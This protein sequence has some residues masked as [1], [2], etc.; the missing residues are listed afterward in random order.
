MLHL[1]CG[2]STEGFV[3]VDIRLDTGATW[4]GDFRDYSEP[5]FTSV[6][7][8]PPYTQEFADVWNAKY[9]TP[10]E[11]Q[12]V[13][14]RCL[15]PGGILGILHLQVIRPYY[16]FK[17]IAWHPVFCGTTKHLR[18]LTVLTKPLAD[19]EESNENITAR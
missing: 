10:A 18:C 16:G 9:P 5:G 1:F 4:V 13:A 3:R 15:I 17:A 14:L 7:A 2:A 12:K 19:E 6:F 11:I 8:D